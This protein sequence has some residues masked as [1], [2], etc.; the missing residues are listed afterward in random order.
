VIRQQL[1]NTAD[2]DDVQFRALAELLAARLRMTEGDWPEARRL[3]AAA[4]PLIERTDDQFYRT[5][6]YALGIAIEASSVEDARRDAVAESQAVADDLLRRLHVLT[7][8]LDE[9]GSPLLPEP[10][11]W[12]RTAEAEYAR[13]RGCPDQ[14]LWAT[15]VAA[16]DDAHCPVPAAAA[17]LRQADALV[18]TGGDRDA[19]AELLRQSLA[20]AT[21]LGAAPLATDIRSLARRAR[22]DLGTGAVQQDGSAALDVTPRELDVLRL[23][24]QGRTNR[25]IGETLFISEKTASVHVTNLL[26]KLGVSSRVEA[27]AIAVRT[28]LAD[29]TAAS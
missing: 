18:R 12:V 20:T 25:Q 13:V 2:A 9:R 26:R 21:E 15:A 5:Q 14:L 29:D 28:G 23:V 11:A 16:W 8:E 1:E 22:L 7:A 3:V 19:A 4:L 6:A 17:R 10:A 24:A 27:A